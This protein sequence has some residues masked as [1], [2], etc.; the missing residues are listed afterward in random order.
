MDIPHTPREK[1][2]SIDIRPSSSDDHHHQPDPF[3]SR[4]NLASMEPPTEQPSYPPERHARF[5]HSS[6]SLSNR[7]PTPAPVATMPMPAGDTGGVFQKLPN[8]K[9][10]TP[11]AKSRNSSWDFLTKGRND[12]QW[13]DF[14]TRNATEE[15]LRFAEG[16][17][18][19]SRPARLYAYLLNLSI[20][21]RWALYI[22]PVAGLLWI[23][24]ILGLTVSPNGHIWHVKLIWWSI[25]MTVVWVGW[26]AA[27]AFSMV[28]PKLLR[29]TIGVA[30]VST[31]HYIDWLN[32]LHRYI[33]LIAWTVAVWVSFQPLI[34]NRMSSEDAAIYTG[35]VQ[36][37]DLIG[38]MLAA[39]MIC[40]AVLLAEKFAIQFVAWKF[41]QRSYEERILEQKV[42]TKSLV[43]LYQY[44]RDIPGRT[45]TL[46][47]GADTP[48]GM[49]NAL[50][51]K[52][53]LKSVFKGVRGAAEGAT[54]A[55][56][57]VASEI[58][59]SSTLQPNSPEAKVNTALASAN[60]TRLL[61]RRI[62]YSFRQ[63]DSTVMVLDDIARFFPTPEQA[64]IAFHV[65]DKDG[66]GDVTRDEVELACLDLHRERLSLAASMKDI[67]SA[68]GRLDNILMSLYVIVAGLIIAVSLDASFTNVLT[69][70]G[71]LVLGLSW[72]I[73]ASASEVLLSIIFIFVKHPYDISDNVHID[74]E[75]YTVKEI[76]LLS[77]VFIDSRGCVVQIPNSA[78]N[79]FPIRN[80][81]RSGPESEPF[82]FDVA[83]DTT[84][85]KIEELRSRMFAFVE[86]KRRDFQP[87]FD[88]V[89]VDIPGQEKMTLSADIRYKSNGHLSALKVKR[90]NMW[91][92]A[93]KNALKELK[94]FGPD[95]DPDA[96]KGPA[97]YTLVPWE[98]VKDDGTSPSQQQG[99]IREPT[100]PK[101][102]YHFADHN[103]VMMDPSADVFGEANERIGAPHRTM[104]QPLVMPTGGGSARMRPRRQVTGTSE[105]YEMKA[106][107]PAGPV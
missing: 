37:L 24:G 14:D 41:H 8:E 16:D 91:I 15:H 39:L 60:K 2:H 53:L 10:D 20:I 61:A 9:G 22:V 52:K 102:D 21:T 65:F 96:P 23:P 105:E 86:S 19:K 85:E 11:P 40:A 25:W 74:K 4:T 54:T 56:G 99:T 50:N 58:I 95:G 42:Q 73:G 18:A 36:V 34:D 79:S 89:V 90:R 45:D 51:P 1:Y 17:F 57:N 103:A 5:G 13:D 31:R 6:G 78:L 107:T 101:T 32:A 72:L 27:L 69:G 46:K 62:F 87:V 33:A 76:R 44:S 84:F 35:S 29:W 43:I 88:V 100:I 77:T 94:I 75:S 83:Y 7:Y 47:D 28:L 82:E 30:A 49:G 71:T 68:V 55:F 3:G 67:D 66:N 104:P 80:H 38:K 12:G 70:A 98:D 92:C 64:Q 106:S 63:E 59:G 93:L 26:W 81:R 48:K 97:K